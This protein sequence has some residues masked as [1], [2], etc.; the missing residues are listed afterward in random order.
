MA[1]W[2]AAGSPWGQRTSWEL[3]GLCE[4]MTLLFIFSSF[5]PRCRQ[6]GVVL[7][8]KLKPEEYLDSNRART[9]C[10]SVTLSEFLLRLEQAHDSLD[11]VGM[12]ENKAKDFG[13]Y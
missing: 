9:A 3:F 6:C 7:K 12:C 2:V 4:H 1:A 10:C 13:L 11:S 8:G 5:W